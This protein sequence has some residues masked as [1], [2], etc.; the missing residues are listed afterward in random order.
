MRSLMMTS[1]MGNI[2]LIFIAQEI[3][4]MI[5]HLT[6]MIIQDNCL[7]TV[8]QFK[9]REFISRDIIMEVIAQLLLIKMVIIQS[10]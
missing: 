2:L 9:M 3:I 6:Q 8:S 10:L 5:R 7:I 1:M 4:M